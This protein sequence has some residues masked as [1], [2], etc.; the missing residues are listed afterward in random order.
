LIFV[1]LLLVAEKFGGKTVI[2]TAAIATLVIFTGLTATVWVTRKDFSFLRGTLMV[3][4]AGAL[5]LIVAGCLF[6]FQLGTIFCVAMV[7]LAGGY[8]LYYTSQILAHYHPQQ[9]VAAALAL[10]SAIALLFWYLI[11]IV[12]RLRE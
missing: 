12:M 3:A 7:V 6:G 4:S 10:F 2:P 5:G 9:Y 1:P 8:I 11:R